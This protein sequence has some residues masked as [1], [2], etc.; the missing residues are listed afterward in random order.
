MVEL[1]HR[2]NMMAMR[3]IGMRKLSAL[4]AALTMPALAAISPE[5]A[6]TRRTTFA[7]EFSRAN[8]V[9]V[10]NGAEVMPAIKPADLTGRL[11]MRGTGT[12]VFKPSGTGVSFTRSGQQNGNTSFYNFTGTGLGEMFEYRVPGQVEVAVESKYSFAERRALPA[13]EGNR[14]IYRF[15]FHASEGEGYTVARVG[16]GVQ[17]DYLAFYATFF[18][19]GYTYFVPRG[20][21][22]ALFGNGVTVRIRV[23]WDGAGR[24]VLYVND[25]QVAAFNYPMV[26]PKWDEK[27]VMSLG[28]SNATDYGGGFWAC[29]DF[30]HTMRV[31]SEGPYVDTIAPSVSFL[32]PRNG[33]AQRGVI[34]LAAKATDNL[35]NPRVQFYMDGAPLGGVVASNPFQKLW[36]SRTVS[37]GRHKLSV[38]ATDEAGNSSTSEV[39]L[40]IVNGVPVSADARPGPP[41]G[42]RVLHTEAGVVRIGWESSTDDVGVARYDIY[43]DDRRIASVTQAAVDQLQSFADLSAETQKEY[44]YK[45]QAVDVA[46]NRSA[47]AAPLWVRTGTGRTL[48]VGPGRAYAKP[49]AAIAAAAPGDTIEVDAAGNG[50]YDGDVCFWSKADLTI[51]GVN[52]MARI[53]A[54]GKNAQG[55]AIWVIAGGNAV[56]E[57]IELS[58]CKVP[59]GNGAGIRAEGPGLFLRRVYFH[60]NENGVLGMGTLRGTITIEF[61]EFA[62]HGTD[63]STHNLYISAVD[64]FILRYSYSHHCR[65]G[66]LV[67]T[68]ARLNHILYNRLTDE[69]G[70]ASYEL[71]IA[72]GGTAYVIGNDIQQSPRSENSNI[73]AFAHEGLHAGVA[74]KLFFLNNT[75]VNNLVADGCALMIDNGV[76]EPPVYQNNVFQTSNWVFCDSNKAKS[77]RVDNYIG[78]DVAYYSPEMHDYR[79]VSV[80]GEQ[81]RGS[82]YGALGLEL[83]SPS[84]VYEHPASASEL[85]EVNDPLIGARWVSGQPGNA[86]SGPDDG[87]EPMQGSNWIVNAASRQ[88]ATLAPASLASVMGDSLTSGTLY[89]PGDNLPEALGGVSAIITDSSGANHTARIS[90]AAPNQVDFYIPAGV[91]SG[92]A[93]LLIRKEDG[94]G[95]DG[96]IIVT[97]TGPGL[98]SA[99][100]SGIGVG[101]ISVIHRDAS[102]NDQWSTAFNGASG[103]MAATP[104][105]VSDATKKVYLQLYGTGIRPANGAAGVT[106]RV[107]GVAVP[108]D[109]VVAHGSLM[110]ID[111]I[112][113]GPL[114]LSLAGSGV[115]T[116]TVTAGGRES[117]AVTVNIQ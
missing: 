20:T 25:N 99:D 11:V 81:R 3:R 40:E 2:K 39:E 112:R 78:N 19:S 21:E 68:R 76:A 82:D 50:T 49:C 71:Q 5:P 97:S 65:S 108:V 87:G 77:I 41:A 23:S 59:D 56:I 117:N 116:V 55:K 100:G 95:V 10:A 98:F 54:A 35:S 107:G 64:N 101:L 7:L 32:E 73:L 83:R 96:S 24:G 46:G 4:L 34:R 16:W 27:S 106:A 67:K 36:D 31:E 115:A 17:D 6:S 79:I 61:S 60:H 88:P 28:A 44:T 38:T 57:N 14:Y 114:P 89:A 93:Q 51:R 84:Y 72:N 1:I 103:T 62:Y 91:A 30:L 33:E 111:E 22:E 66:H 47:F 42:Q 37:D 113:V 85:M 58:G 110:G 86:G 102:G 105:S 109:S 9:Q 48:L 26:N 18:N 104:I 70:T 53:D 69:D 75:V 90:M 80:G 13:T 74:P 8:V 45:I 29:D 92:R 94:S 63:G 15:A 12:P 43:R 52:G